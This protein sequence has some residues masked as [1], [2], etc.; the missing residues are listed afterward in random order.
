[1]NN[2]E[3]WEHVKLIMSMCLDCL[4]GGITKETFIA[5]L[6]MLAKLLEGENPDGV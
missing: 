6:L 5:N 4:Q 2:E 1:M 3:F